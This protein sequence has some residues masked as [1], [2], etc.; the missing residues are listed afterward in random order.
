MRCFKHAILSFG[1]LP[2]RNVA[3]VYPHLNRGGYRAKREIDTG[4]IMNETEVYGST[5]LFKVRPGRDEMKQELNEHH[6]YLERNV[7]LR[8]DDLLKRI[9]VLESC[10][11]TLL[12]KLAQA[13]RRASEPERVLSWSENA[14]LYTQW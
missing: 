4:K 7:A 2:H 14:V 12:E 5:L 6:F 8:S 13:P 11:F 10:Q 1:L 3:A 9:A